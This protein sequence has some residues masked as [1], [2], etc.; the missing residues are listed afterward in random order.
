M[1]PPDV[2]TPPSVA[3]AANAEVHY[4][5]QRLEICRRT[6]RMFAFLMGLQFVAGVVLSLWVSPRTWAGA[7]SS[8][9][10]HVWAAV[11]LGGIISGFPMV[12]AFRQPGTVLSRHVIAA[13]QMLMSALLIHLTG[14]RIETHFHIFGSLA[15]LAMSMC[16]AQAVRP[17]GLWARRLG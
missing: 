6:D 16:P 17:C 10:P 14:G 11:L 8:V 3:H 2:G 15:F 5:Q 12:L 4:E 1:N 9:H 13:G 7:E